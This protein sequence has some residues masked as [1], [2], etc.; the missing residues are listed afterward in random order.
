MLS[1]LTL[2]I[3]FKASIAPESRLSLM[4]LLKRAIAIATRALGV[5]TTPSITFIVFLKVGSG[6][7]QPQPQGGGF[8]HKITLSGHVLLNPCGQGGVKFSVRCFQ[9]AIQYCGFMRRRRSGPICRTSLKANSGASL[10]CCN[11]GSSHSA[12]PL[13]P[14]NLG[15]I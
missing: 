11:P 8:Y 13:L 1:S 2:P 3:R 9:H 4:K 6:V 5:A 14:N 15:A 7:S 10:R 12:R